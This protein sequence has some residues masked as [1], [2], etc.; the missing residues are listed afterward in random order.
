[1]VGRSELDTF[2]SLTCRRRAQ[3]GLPTINIPALFAEHGCNDGVEVSSM[4]T[5]RLSNLK[6]LGL[7]E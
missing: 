4:Y 7:P 2:L 1:M 3:Y 5:R 6:I